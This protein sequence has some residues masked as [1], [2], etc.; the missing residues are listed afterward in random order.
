MDKDLKVLALSKDKAVSIKEV[1]QIL[2]MAH[3]AVVME[4]GGVDPA[5]EAVQV[6]PVVG[7]DA[8][9]LLMVHQTSKEDQMAEERDSVKDQ[10]AHMA[11]RLLEDSRHLAMDNQAAN[12][13][14][15]K[16]QTPVICH[17]VLVLKGLVDSTAGLVDSHLHRMVRLVLVVVLEVV[18]VVRAV[19]AM[20]V[21]DQAMMMDNL[22]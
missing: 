21:V 3:Q 20:V 17:L 14:D 9:G 2:D 15:L 4:M 5:A 16:R 10:I 13:K 18:A 22:M 11:R 19:E 1:P 12:V 7:E 6:V 8:Q